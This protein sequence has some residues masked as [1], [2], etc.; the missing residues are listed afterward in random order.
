MSNGR[1][2]MWHRMILQQGLVLTL[3][4][5]VLL[6]LPTDLWAYSVFS[7]ETLVDAAWESSMVPLL[8]KRFPDA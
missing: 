6:G 2:L 1:P 4:Y 7:H 8:R 5:L 3:A